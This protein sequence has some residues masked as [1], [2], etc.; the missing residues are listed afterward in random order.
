MLQR[1]ESAAC[2]VEQEPSSHLVT[3]TCWSNSSAADL[4]S[5]RYV[6][7]LNCLLLTRHMAPASVSGRLGGWAEVTWICFEGC[8]YRVFGRRPE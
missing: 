7:F 2:L 6:T 5:S 8:Y 4:R 3:S 1:V